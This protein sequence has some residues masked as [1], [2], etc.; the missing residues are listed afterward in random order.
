MALGALNICFK[1]ASAQALYML[2]KQMPDYNDKTV[3]EIAHD[4][5]AIHFMA[6]PCVQKWLTQLFKGN[7]HVKE[8][9]WGFFRLPYWFK[10]SS[11]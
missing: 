11:G 2:G 6:H 4:A 9:E 5:R 8:L 7:L 10:V 3:V 1:D